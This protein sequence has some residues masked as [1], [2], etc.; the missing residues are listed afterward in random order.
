MIVNLCQER[1][2][3]ACLFLGAGDTVAEFWF[4]SRIQRRYQNTNFIYFRSVVL[5]FYL[6]LC[7]NNVMLHIIFLDISQ[8][9]E[10]TTTL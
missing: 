1:V 6:Y 8:L 3:C 9:G 5:F 10:N 4:S 2:C 7:I